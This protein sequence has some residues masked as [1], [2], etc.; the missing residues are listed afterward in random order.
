LQAWASDVFFLIRE[1]A[2]EETEVVQQQ[3]EDWKW[4]LGDW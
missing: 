2:L 4:P 3:F 1:L